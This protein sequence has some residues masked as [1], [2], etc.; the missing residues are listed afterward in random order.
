MPDLVGLSAN[1]ERRL[2]KLIGDDSI[3]PWKVE[4]KGKGVYIA[5]RVPMTEKPIPAETFE[6]LLCEMR[7]VIYPQTNR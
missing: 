5:E 4:R 2:R 1:Q 7:R 6:D 3:H